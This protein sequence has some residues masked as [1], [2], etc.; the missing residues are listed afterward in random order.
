MNEPTMALSRPSSVARPRAPIRAAVLRDLARDRDEVRSRST[1]LATCIVGGPDLGKAWVVGAARREAELAGF[2]TLLCR[3]ER[4]DALAPLSLF[5]A[6]LGSWHPSSSGNDADGGPTRPNGSE[7]GGRE[8]G[9][10]RMAIS[11]GGRFELS[12][13]VLGA[14]IAPAEARESAGSGPSAQA[15]Y[16]HLVRSLADPN[17]IAQEKRARLLTQIRQ[18]LVDRAR[19]APL[20]LALEDLQ[21]ADH[22]S[23]DLV[24]VLLEWRTE[25]PLWILLTYTR[26]EDL[27]P[28]LQRALE[29]T[30]LSQIAVRRPLSPLPEGELRSFLEEQERGGSRSAVPESVVTEIV[31][32]SNGLPGLATRLYRSYQTHGSLPGDPSGGGERGPAE[33]PI[34]HLTE[35]QERVFAIAAVAGPSVP[36]ELLR[37]AAGEEEERM[38]ELLEELVH[39]GLLE[40]QGGT[41]YGFVEDTT[42]ERVYK[43]LTAARRRVLHRK[44]GEA[45]ESFPASRDPTRTFALAHHFSQGRVDEKALT[46]LQAAL[47]IARSM[48]SLPKERELLEQV[49]TVHQRSGPQDVRGEAAILHQLGSTAYALGADDE[50]MQALSRARDLLGNLH[51]RGSPYGGVLLDLARVTARGKDPAVA[52]SLAEE[53][54]ARFEEAGDLLGVAWVRRFLSRLDYTAGDYQSARAELQGCREALEKAKAP[55]GEIGRT[56]TALADVEFMIDPETR[57]ASTALLEA[58][59]REL[60]ADGDKTGALFAE[61]G[62]AA[63]EHSLNDPEAARVT[64]DRAL[65]LIPEVPEAWRLL[66][67]LLRKASNH[68]AKGE[69]KEGLAVAEALVDLSRALKDRE[70]EAR[71]LLTCADLAGRM[72][73][74]ERGEKAALASLEVGRAIGQRRAQAEALYRLAFASNARGDL[75]EAAERLAEAEKL[76]QGEELSRTAQFLRR[77]LSEALQEH[78]D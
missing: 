25:A 47:E 46:H 24:A 71:A 3:A 32:R 31:R 23:A 1:T 62:R 26:E 69:M 56:L 6:A 52:R 35:E 67:S 15:E 64:M 4:D 61:L 66:D 60:L 33:D 43:D 9:L 36:F 75:R 53:A 40:E 19:E 34:A 39:R 11:P 14:G 7:A 73:L 76:S 74:L 41:I 27:Y 20:L 50:A 2:E 30:F 18:F 10:S 16:E 8:E 17:Q 28:A 22:V 54:L 70:R 63:I 49:H 21:L 78:R 59:I 72:V 37:R 29:R 44:V 48:G 58:G 42:R 68:A 77:E 65:A 55:R 51:E 57:E 5:R 38:A 45:L 12:T 13:L